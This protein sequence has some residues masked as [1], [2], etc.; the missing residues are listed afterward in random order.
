MVHVVHQRQTEPLAQ[1]QQVGRREHPVVVLQR[2]P[3]RALAL[4]R[5]TARRAGPAPL[6]AAGPAAT[7]EHD[8]VRPHQLRDRRLELELADRALHHRLALRV[9]H[10]ELVGMK[11]QPDVQLARERAGLE[12]RP[13]DG[14]VAVEPVEL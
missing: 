2:E 5:S 8:H 11:A 10:H 3:A 6:G 14:A 7:V 4:S 13:P 9:E 1:R 12:E